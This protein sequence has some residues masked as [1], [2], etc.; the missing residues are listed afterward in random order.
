MSQVTRQ[1]VKMLDMLPEQEQQLAYE[2]IK[3]IVLAW[4]SDFTKTTPFERKRLTKADKE[5]INGEI[6]DHSEIDWN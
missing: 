1:I 4:D 6:V 2:L 5:I 3:R